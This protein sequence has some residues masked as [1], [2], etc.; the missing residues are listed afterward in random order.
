MQYIG[1]DKNATRKDAISDGSGKLPEIRVISGLERLK[2]WTWKKIMCS[3]HF[4]GLILNYLPSYL[5]ENK[6]F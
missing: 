5:S 3:I 1:L 4:F 6:I 2:F